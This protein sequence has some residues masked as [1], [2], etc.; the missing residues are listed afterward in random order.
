VE[1][2]V[3]VHFIP[4]KRRLGA[5]VR[6]IRSTLRAYPLMDVAGLFLSNPDNYLIKIEV[7]RQQEGKMP[8]R[9]YQCPECSAV[10]LDAEHLQEHL[11]ARHMEDLFDTVVTEGAP[12]TGSFVCVGRC[13]MSGDLL[14]PPNYHGFEEAIRQLHHTRFS[15][16]TYDEY[17]GRVEMVHDPEVVEQW[18]QQASRQVR[19]KLKGD[20]QAEELTWSQAET[21]FAQQL[22]P[23]FIHGTTRVMVP[24][25]AGRELG[26]MPV[27]QAM[28]R[29]WTRESHHPFTLSI[30]LRPA[31]KHMGLHLFKAGEGITFV[32][33]VKP[34][35]IDPS[36]AVENI[37]EALEYLQEHPGC[38]RREMAEGLRPKVSGEEQLA[39]MMKPL[40]WLIERGHVIEFFNG[41][42]SV[43]KSKTKV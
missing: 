14:G 15:H 16:L 20:E 28:R 19:Y 8:L 4:E 26:E 25:G 18:K 1:L 37:R 9:F 33:A 27:K 36:H 10:Y 40:R 13:G 41:T 17:R 35:P 12:P 11:F 43:P 7:R 38:T 24:A 23:K 2:P 30:A 29:A 5:V 31:F 42:L 3:D 21:V 39:E 34:N 32:T 22:A 6:Q